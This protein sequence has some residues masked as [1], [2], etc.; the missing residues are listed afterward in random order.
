MGKER[1]F[2]EWMGSA[3]GVP[4][5][6]R[7][8]LLGALAAAKSGLSGFDESDAIAL[9]L[10]A[11]KAAAAL[12]HSRLQRAKMEFVAHASHSLKEPLIPIRSYIEMLREDAVDDESTRQRYFNA[13]LRAVHTFDRVT[14]ELLKATE[15][16]T[17][18]REKRE[19]FSAWSAVQKAIEEVQIFTGVS[20]TW[21]NI[22]EID[23]VTGERVRLEEVVRCILDN[24]IKYS[25][26]EPDIAVKMDSRDSSVFIRVS[27]KGI[28]MTADDN[29]HAFEPFFR[30]SAERRLGAEEIPGTGLGLHIC[31]SYI[32]AMQGK[33]HIESTPGYGTTLTVALPLA[34]AS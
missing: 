31:Y 11:A 29:A 8:N 25:A 23:I 12:E 28:G 16:E 7:E 20:I 22:A 3:V 10:L 32:Q 33:I 30:G 4:L 21:N 9:E 14:S 27:D 13:I 1:R 24:A 5:I 2:L 26:D 6:F 15:I 17:G 34:P 19:R 18:M